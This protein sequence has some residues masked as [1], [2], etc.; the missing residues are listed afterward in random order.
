MAPLKRVEAPDQALVEA[1]GAL[2][3]SKRIDEHRRYRRIG[4]AALERQ[5]HHVAA[6]AAAEI[7]FLADP[8]VYRPQVGLALPPVVRLLEL[9]IDDLHDADRA[10]IVLADQQLAP[11]YIARQ[12]LGPGVCVVAAGSGDDVRLG[13]PALQQG[14]SSMVARHSCKSPSSR[15][16]PR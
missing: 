1:V 13:V 10:A 15:P 7:G 16:S 14:R 8:D 11:G 3:G 5:T 9:R 2:V 6:E 4:K 12:F